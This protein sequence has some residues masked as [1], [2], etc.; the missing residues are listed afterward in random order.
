MVRFA[1]LP[2]WFVLGFLHWSNQRNTNSSVFLCHLH[3]DSKQHWGQRYR[4]FDHHRERHCAVH[5]CVFSEHIHINQGHSN[6][7]NNTN[8][9]RWHNHLMVC[10]TML[11][12]PWIHRQAQSAVRQQQSLLRAPTPSREPTPVVAIRQL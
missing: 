6:D 1:L 10:F 3:R 7:H 2:S 12:W 8:I 5:D 9:Q 11:D 4:N